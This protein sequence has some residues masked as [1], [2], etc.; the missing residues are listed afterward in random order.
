MLKYYL[1]SKRQLCTG[2]LKI[3][4]KKTCKFIFRIPLN[5]YSETTRIKIQAAVF[6]LK[7]AKVCTMLYKRN[8]QSYPST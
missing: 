4:Y 6:G 8:A 7:F 3:N 2:V 5:H 1:F